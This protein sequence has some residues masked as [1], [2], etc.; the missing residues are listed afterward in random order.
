MS[1][2][3][4]L[5]IVPERVAAP[6]RRASLGQRIAVGSVDTLVSLILN[7]AVVAWMLGIG[8]PLRVHQPPQAISVELVDKM[9]G[10]GGAKGASGPVKADTSSDASVQPKGE[11]KTAAAEST[12]P[13]ASHEPAKS[14]P[15]AKAEE[16]PPAPADEP[17]PPPETSPGPVA[18]PPFAEPDA[19][20]AAAPVPP[21]PEHP[22]DDPK[23]HL[24]E[25]PLPP[26]PEPHPQPEK[27]QPSFAAP[28][29]RD[30]GTPTSDSPAAKPVAAAAE[31]SETVPPPSP[32][33]AAPKPLTAEQ[34]R[35]AQNTALL[36]AM[37][38]FGSSIGP[39]PMQAPAEA[40][41]D[42]TAYRGQVYANFNKAQD[43]IADAKA[44][45]LKGQAVVAF[46]IDDHGNIAS[47][48][49]AV[50]SRNPAVDEAA[51]DLIRRAA[52]FPPPPP[53]AQRSFSPAI[54]LGL[55]D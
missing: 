37:L 45:H 22:N 5:D 40:Q 51:L 26:P 54:G 6:L 36:A 8:F 13:Q 25:A 16:P 38:P 43:V 30:E 17:S 46:T 4:I 50:S 39:D 47:I 19:A 15:V 27:P 48:G 33:P 32:P 3:D 7:G 52:P 53:G 2:P 14:A 12:P 55:D 42:S 21:P 29:Q 18:A 9:P 34:K 44:R 41:G 10:S 11:T 20:K 31:A 24:V 23:A 28:A 35:Q 49:I 1:S